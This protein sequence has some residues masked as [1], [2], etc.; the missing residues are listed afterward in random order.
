MVVPVD[1]TVVLKIT[2]SDVIHSWWIPKL[3]GKV[4]GVPGHDERDLV[5]D[6]A[7]QGGTVYKGQCAELCGANHADMRAAVQGRARPSEYQRWAER[8]SADIEARR[9]SC[10]PSSASGARAEVS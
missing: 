10:W 6:P 5:Q 7:R 9:T 1:T 4:D 3:G 8:Q 2:A